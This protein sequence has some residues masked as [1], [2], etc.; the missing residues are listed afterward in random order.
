MKPNFANVFNVSA[1]ENRSEFVLSFFQMY[2]KHNYTPS[3]QGLI[4][5]PEKSVDEVAS[6]L[7]TRDGALALIGLLQ[8]TLNIPEE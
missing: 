5:C 1:N 4:D 8:K 3:K 2:M 7:M 6:V